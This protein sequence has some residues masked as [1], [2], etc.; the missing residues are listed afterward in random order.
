MLPG[1]K[2]PYIDRKNVSLLFS[3]NDF[4]S[5][6]NGH[7]F[8][9]FQPFHSMNFLQALSRAQADNKQLMILFSTITS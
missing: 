4:S 9:Y 5:I 3:F 6:S 8:L 2:I 7:D 1:D